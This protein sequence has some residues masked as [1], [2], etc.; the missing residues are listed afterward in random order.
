MGIGAGFVTKANMFPEKYWLE[1]VFPVEIG[2]LM[3]PWLLGW[4]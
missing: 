3:P 4:I 2:L 1:D